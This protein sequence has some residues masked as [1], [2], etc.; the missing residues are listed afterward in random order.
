MSREGTYVGLSESEKSLLKAL[1]DADLPLPPEFRGRLFGLPGGVELHWP[2]KYA[3]S[4]DYDQPVLRAVERYSGIEEGWRDRLI[5][6]DNTEVLQ[7]LRTGP[8]RAEI[9]AG[10]GLRLIY[11]DPPFLTG[12]TFA[13]EVPIGE[14]RSGEQRSISLP[15]YS[16]GAGGG[17]AAYLD[18]MLVRLRLMHDLL[19]DDGSLYFHCDHRVSAAMR[20][21][22]D[23][24]FGPDRLLNEIV[25]HYGLGNPGGRRAF[26]RKHDTILLYTKSDNY[27]FNR[28]RGE[29]TPAMAAKYRHEDEHGRYL[30]SYGK[31]YYLKG[32]KPYDSVWTIPTLGAT[33]GQRNGYPTQKPEALLERILLASSNPGDLVADF[34]CGSGTLAAVAARLDRRWLACD[35]SLRA[36]QATR[37]RLLAAGQ[38]G[39][40][41]LE[42][43]G[44]ARPSAPVSYDATVSA[45]TERTGDQVIVRLTGFCPVEQDGAAA[46]GQLHIE[47]GQLV[48]RLRLPRE[49]TAVASE[50]LTDHWTD[51]V[52]AWAVGI[53]TVDEATSTTPFAPAWWA[54]RTGDGRTLS[55]A[56]PPISVPAAGS[57]RVVVKVV[58]VLCGETFTEAE[59][60]RTR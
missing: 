37:A 2:G 20:L 60:V 27:T 38:T 8:L 36:I 34:C 28:L 30:L 52:E 16:D 29:V 6:G 25:W 51:W 46:R 13:V 55:L 35:A 42:L 50:T 11:L 32:G 33:D 12:R 44:N 4:S 21:V 26:A 7:S 14:A 17:L 15:A 5:L 53:E 47:G 24:V 39:F 43:A 31:K 58:D 56:S 10:G 41:L 40:D 48:R 3:L 1:I 22:L 54:G 59:L 49:S 19:A 18:A 45:M 23:E 57:Y 9:E